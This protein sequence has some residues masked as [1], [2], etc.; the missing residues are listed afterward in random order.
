MPVYLFT[1]FVLS[2]STFLVVFITDII[3]RSMVRG[4][5]RKKMPSSGERRKETD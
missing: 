5:F 3:G 2:L 1:Y 4:K